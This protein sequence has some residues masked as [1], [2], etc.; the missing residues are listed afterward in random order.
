MQPAG[1]DQD[2]RK[3][4]LER[5][6]SQQLG[7]P[8]SG[9][10]ASADASF[11][12]YFRFQLADRTVI[13]MDAPPEKEDSRPFVDVDRRLAAAGVHVPEVIAADLEQ[14]FLLLGDMGTQTWLQ[15]LTPENADEHFRRAIETLLHVQQADATGLPEYDEALLRRELELFPEWYLRKHLGRDVNAELRAELDRTFD[16]L[17]E[18]ALAQERVF[19]HRDFMP[20]NLMDSEPDPGVIDFQDAVLGP[21]SYDPICLFRDAFVSWPTAHVDRWLEQYWQRACETG[22]PV[23]KLFEDFLRDCDLMGAQ[24]HLKV[25]GIF[26]RICHR[27]GKPHYVE[28]VPRFFHYLREVI[29]RRPELEPLANVLKQIGELSGPGGVN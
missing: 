15:V 13:G 24:R 19:V 7:E 6:A 21:V 8:V 25:I 11:R 3:Q 16:L 26:A 2:T 5:W 12:R 18:S 10:P 28:D 4:A 23:P 29:R 27:D 22:L 20:R 14:G 17:V 1:Q 9:V